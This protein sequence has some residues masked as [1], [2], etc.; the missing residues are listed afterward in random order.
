[1]TVSLEVISDVICP[2]CFIGKRRLEQAW[3]AITPPVTVRWLPFQL[4]PGMPPEGIERR[5]YRIRK[6][7]SWER[8]RQLDAQVAAVGREV[9][10]D[11]AFDKIARTPNTAA[12]HRLIAFA[13]PSGQQDAVVERLFQAYFVEGRDLCRR[14]T[15][16]DL[17][18]EAG[19][20]RQ[21]ALQALQERAV[22]DATREAQHLIARHQINGVPALIINRQ[23][24]LSGAQEPATILQAIRQA[25]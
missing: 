19:V 13:E 3:A 18:A 8:S 14:D 1:M 12:A 25:T 9:G 2:W 20:D 22:D 23:V 17:V 21:A 16:L 24:F 11:F 10:I 5:E 7:G 15:L 4:N 6:F